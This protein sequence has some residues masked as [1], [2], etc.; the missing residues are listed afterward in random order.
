[1]IRNVKDVTGLLD[2]R[3]GAPA[4]SWLSLVRVV[5]WLFIGLVLIGYLIPAH[6]VDISQSQYNR[7][8]KT[9]WVRDVTLDHNDP[10]GFYY[11]RPDHRTFTI[12]WI[13]PSTLQD[14]SPGHYSFIPA[15]V[16]RIL[17]QIDGRPLRVDM[18]FLSGARIFDLY[19][20]AVTALARHPDMILVDLNPLWVF[21]PTAVQ[22]WPSLNGTV[23]RHAVPDPLSWPLL[24]GLDTPEDVALGVGSLRLPAIRNRWSYA[25][26]LRGWVDGLWPLRLA[27]QMPPAHPTALQ[28]TQMMEA[29]LDFWLRFRP[30]VS[31]KAP[32]DVRQLALLEESKVDGSVLND[33]IVTR[34]LAALGG[35]GIPAIAYMAPVDPAALVSPP[36]DAA[37]RGIEDHL[38]TI[39]ARHR[40]HTLFVQWQSGTRLLPPMKF[41]D[42]VHLAEDG[43]YVS[44]LAGLICRDLVAL[45][46]AT[47]CVPTQQRG[48]P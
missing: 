10:R 7:K 22:S 26:S 5:V 47:Q 19:A 38:R 41:N 12:A 25:E 21:N 2:R 27:P 20:A 35:S 29:P 11:R 31:P 37:L 17:P 33:A 28:Q 14:I 42:I 39:A 18:Y 23:F 46:P 16:R 32:M 36:V 48:Q 6:G 15:D 13:G 45:D 44:Y 1:M 40:F 8:I 4:V 30:V 34:L 9:T 43:P 24:A 3:L